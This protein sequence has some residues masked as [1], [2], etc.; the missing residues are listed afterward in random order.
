MSANTEPDYT[1]TIKNKEIWEF[2]NE[3]QSID[4]ENAVLI[5][6]DILDL[7]VKNAEQTVS[8]KMNTRILSSITEQMSQMKDLRTDI[9]NMKQEF[10][11]INTELL[12]SLIIKFSDIKRE[13]IDEMKNIMIYNDS[14]SLDKITSLID[15]NNISLVDKTKLLL[16]DIV[17]RTNDAYYRQIQDSI[18]LFQK[19]IIDETTK[20]LYNSKTENSLDDFLTNFDLKF[21]TMTQSVQTPIYSFISASEERINK[22][23]M[24]MKEH[25]MSKETVQDKLFSELDDFLNK[26]KYKNSSIRGK[27][28]ENQLEDILNQMFP[29]ALVK[30]TSGITASGDFIL[31]ERENGKHNILFEN[32]HYTSNVNSDEVLKFLRD[33]REQK[34]NGI[35]LSQTSGIVTKKQFQI[36]IIDSL[37]VVYVLNCEYDPD[38]IKIAVD[39]IDTLSS[40]L[41][42]YINNGED[43]DNTTIP[44]EIMQRMNEEYSRLCQQKL[45]LIENLKTFTKEMTKKLTEQI[46]ELKLPTLNTFLSAKFGNY[47]VSIATDT[48]N[49]LACKY[50]KKA[51]ATK[52][53]L[54]SH[55]K[56]CVK[57]A[58]LK[59]NTDG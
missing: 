27:T 42:S 10:S 18:L 57:K 14:T 26:N 35:M 8:N 25:A 36:E 16:T 24:L 29:S 3:N 30:N 2:F 19:N 45:Y 9:A 5:L 40:C 17:P 46:E 4:F 59:P 34:C 15:K 28:G 54:A 32:K 31:Q 20:L 12:S 11:K 21:T 47:N 44:I 13:Y 50:C 58:A 43:A 37:V 23:L 51:W 53:S 1:I 39:I 6:I 48:D 33:V 41:D 52:A 38:K 55:M 22:N 7:T 49:A 56:G